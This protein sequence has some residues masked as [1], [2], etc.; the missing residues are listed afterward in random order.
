MA[1]VLS[2]LLGG[3]ATGAS[4][5]SFVP[6]IGTGIGAAGGGLLGLLSGLF[7]PKPEKPQ[8]FNPKQAQLQNQAINQALQILNTGRAQG[9][10]PFAQRARQQFQ[11]QTVPSLAERFSALNAQ[12]SS[13]FQSAIGRA[14]SDLESQLAG[15]ESQY[16]QDQLRSL[17]STSLAPLD[18]TRP[19][20]PGFFESSGSSA[21]SLLPLLLAQQQ[22]S[23]QQP[24]R[25]L[26]GFINQPYQQLLQSSQPQQPFSGLFNNL[27]LN[28]PTQQFGFPGANYFANQ[29]SDITKTFGFPGYNFLG[30]NRLLGSI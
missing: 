12:P 5:G 20:G 18:V 3:A 15:L 22:S 10:E 1:N 6:G 2:E 23:Q 28:N 30:N 7:G 14:G 17:L 9:F 25:Q 4:L 27:G 8:P 11:T 13:A 26:G 16:S 24:T 21:L 19:A 29:G